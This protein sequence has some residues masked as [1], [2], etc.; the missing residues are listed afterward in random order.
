MESILNKNTDDLI[1]RIQDE[2]SKKIYLLRVAFS[3][4]NDYFA[5]REIVR[6]LPEGKYLFDKL[7]LW[8]DDEIYIFGAGLRGQALFKILPEGMIGGFIDN[9]PDKIGTEF[10]GL[11][12]YSLNE[13]CRRKRIIIAN[14]WFYSEIE[15]QI[16]SEGWSK[17]RIIN[18]A[19]LWNRLIDEQYFDVP[20]IKSLSNEVFVDAGGFDGYDT[21]KFIKWA[22]KNA[23]MS[24]ISEPDNKNV[25]S[26]RK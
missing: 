17:D 11:K 16:V 3:K 25:E 10:C 12:V 2:L 18:I 6:L 20:F 7:N 13:I 15:N 8:C 24:F 1:S 23:E 26:C 19:P 4:T 22:D 9:N 5:I 14:R 21:V